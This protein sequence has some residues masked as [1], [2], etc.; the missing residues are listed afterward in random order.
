MDSIDGG[1]LSVKKIVPSVKVPTWVHKKGTAT[2]TVVFG[3]TS[4][5]LTTR[6]KHVSMGA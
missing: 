3:V 2:D 1:D 6:F 4:P 5:T